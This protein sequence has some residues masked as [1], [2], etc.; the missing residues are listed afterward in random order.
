[1]EAYMG[2]DNVNQPNDGSPIESADPTLNLK[3]EFNRKIG[4][5]QEQLQKNNEALQAL[6][7]RLATQDKPRSAETSANTP[8]KSS[9]IKELWYQDEAAA[10]NLIVEEAVQRA[11]GSIRKELETERKVTQRES[12]V[13][14]EIFQ[15]YPEIGDQNSALYKKAVETYNAL[16]EEDRANPLAY[17]V[18][19]RDAAIDLGVQPMKKRQS[20]GNDDFTMSSGGYSSG[21]QSRGK[22]AD[23][24]APEALAFAQAV[25]LNINDKKTLENL[26]NHSKREWLKYKA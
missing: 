12:R 2:D 18:A 25:G 24:I 21:S 10:A 7:N 3:S 26:K 4:N 8:D 19:V 11:T 1:M 5:V 22:K 15:D 14:N 16:P 6:M 13:L 17:K 9:K 23:D 20:A